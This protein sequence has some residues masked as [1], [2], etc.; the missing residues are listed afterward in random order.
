MKRQPET[1]WLADVSAHAILDTV[2]RL[3]GALRGRVSEQKAGRG[4]GFPRP[5]KKFVNE[6]GIYCIGQATEFRDRAVRVPKLGVIRLRGGA[7]P[8]G[9]LLSARIW[10]DGDRWMISGQFECKQPAPMPSSDITIGVDLGVTT[11]VTAYDGAVFD[12]IAAPKRL[13]KAQKRLRR[14]QRELSRRKKGSARRRV[15]ARRVA[16]IHRKTR[17]QRKDL[18]HQISHRLTAKAG[19]L[20]FETLNVKGMMRNRHL[21]LSVADAGMSRLVTFCTY[22][23]DWRGRTIVKI[24]PWFPGSQTCCRCGQRHPEMRRLS[25]R[26]MIC[27]CGNT[28]SRDRNAAINHFKYPEERGNG[29]SD[30]PTRVEIGVQEPAPVPIGETRILHVVA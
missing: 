26:T 2:A 10:R 1:V 20:K 16:A 9:R 18:L 21:A 8:A 29:S 30:A 15:A 25:V 27:D 19:V 7:L 28:I 11:L 12:E 13:R 4:C 23:A 14:A 22:K 3:D 5:K 6:A 24:D 17:E